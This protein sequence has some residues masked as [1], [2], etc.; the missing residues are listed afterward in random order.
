MPQTLWMYSFP[1]CLFQV[2]ACIS[3]LE[4]SGVVGIEKVKRFNIGYCRL[5]A[6]LISFSM[7][8]SLVL[9]VSEPQLP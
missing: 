9:H 6:K 3:G 7:D 1:F 5:S 2:V 8:D 4:S